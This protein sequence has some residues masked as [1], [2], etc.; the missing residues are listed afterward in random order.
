[1][2]CS[3]ISYCHSPDRA[4]FMAENQPNLEAPRGH[5]GNFLTLVLGGA[6]IVGVVW[7]VATHGDDIHHLLYP[8]HSIGEP[9]VPVPNNFEGLAVTDAK[10]TEADAK[11]LKTMLVNSHGELNEKILAFTKE[12]GVTVDSKYI[13]E[14]KVPGFDKVSE[15]RNAPAVPENHSINTKPSPEA[16]ASVKDAAAPVTTPP[17][18]TVATLDPTHAQMAKDLGMEDAFFKGHT[19]LGEDGITY[20]TDSGHTPIAKIIN[21]ADMHH[22]YAHE[23]GVQYVISTIGDNKPF[24][25]VNMLNE[26]GIKLEG[27]DHDVIYYAKHA[28]DDTNGPMKVGCQ[29]ITD[30]KHN[31]LIKVEYAA[32]CDAPKDYVPTP[33]KPVIIPIEKGCDQSCPTDVLKAEINSTPETPRHIEKTELHTPV[34][35]PVFEIANCHVQTHTDPISKD[36][37]ILSVV[38]TDK[39][40][41]AS[42]TFTSDEFFAKYS[43]TIDE[44]EVIPMNGN[45]YDRNQYLSY[46][47]HIQQRAAYGAPVQLY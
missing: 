15:G 21:L 22:W 1:M 44:K 43:D 42:K 37:R 14:G 4:I 6:T 34:G 5:R 40:T 23:K 46:I 17:P 32:S 47:A 16:Q 33:P 35:E 28:T 13:A 18:E 11:Q 2:Y 10:F 24:Q 30:W 41:G 39:T 45:Y 31:D 20:I 12:H 29:T 26:A 7:L 36:G 38:A 25:T 27:A 9:D 8:A 19:V 3:V